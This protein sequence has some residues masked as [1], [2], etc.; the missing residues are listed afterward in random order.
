MSFLKFL[1]ALRVSESYQSVWLFAESS[2]KI[3][4]FAKKRVYRLMKASDVV[5]S[6]EQVKNTSGKK[7]KS[8]ASVEAGNR[9]LI[10]NIWLY[11][12]SSDFSC[13]MLINGPENQLVV[14]QLLLALFLKKF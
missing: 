4:D 12:A 9:V 8:N 2:Y 14:Q 13:Y 6:K 10:S 11:L 1:D 3:F 7:R 5:K